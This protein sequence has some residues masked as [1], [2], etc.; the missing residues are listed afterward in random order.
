MADHVEFVVKTARQPL[1][2]GA[3]RV[4]RLPRSG[5]AA[6]GALV[7]SGAEVLELG[8]V[9]LAQSDVG[10]R[11][12]RTLRA[13][14][15]GL[16]QQPGT[17][18]GACVRSLVRRPRRSDASG[19]A[20][21]ASPLRCVGR[22]LGNR[23]PSGAAQSR[24][25]R[26]SWPDGATPFAPGW[27]A[28][29]A[30]GGHRRVATTGTPAAKNPPASTHQLIGHGHDQPVGGHQ[31]QPATQFELCRRPVTSRHRQPQLRVGTQQYRQL[32]AGAVFA[33]QLG[34]SDRRA[35][36][37]RQVDGADQLDTTEPNRLGCGPAPPPGASLGPRSAPIWPAR[38][39]LGRLSPTLG[40][41][42]AP[43]MRDA[44]CRA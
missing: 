17:V 24:A 34:A 35:S 27:S 29:R 14:V 12:E 7:G 15:D 18:V 4:R 43:P 40:R 39:Q 25:R 8:Q 20:V 6:P 31:L 5:P 16:G 42:G 37:A 11:V 22:W 9:N 2:T 23:G 10:N 19:R 33:D 1:V 21:S 36:L 41:S 30:A 38:P 28:L 26:R 32:A 44:G 13:E 3:Q